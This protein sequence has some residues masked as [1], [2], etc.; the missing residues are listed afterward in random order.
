MFSCCFPTDSRW[1]QLSEWPS[2]IWRRCSLFSA[3][4]QLQFQWCDE[5][6]DN[7]SPVETLTSCQ[8]FV[9]AVGDTQKKFR[10]WKSRSFTGFMCFLYI[11]LLELNISV[12]FWEIVLLAVWNCTDLKI[13]LLLSKICRGN[14]KIRLLCKLRLVSV[15]DRLL[16]RYIVIVVWH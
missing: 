6:V 9:F 8:Q 5:A 13:W 15:V 14:I 2:G 3:L 12:V 10:V 16:E 1:I 11:E 7:H 4:V